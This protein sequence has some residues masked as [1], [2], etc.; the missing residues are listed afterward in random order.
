MTGIT[1]VLAP[2]DQKPGPSNPYAPSIDRIN[3]GKGYTKENC[4]V[5]VMALNAAM[6][7]WGEK[8]T[9]DVMERWFNAT[10]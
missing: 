4:R 2:V 5:I 6:G 10:G 3:P 1:F 7:C 9:R 8:I